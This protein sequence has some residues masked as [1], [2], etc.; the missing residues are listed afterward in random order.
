MTMPE[1]TA[2]TS[3]YKA[4]EQSQQQYR[5]QKSALLY[6]K[7]I[8]PAQQLCMDIPVNTEQI[9]PCVRYADGTVGF[10]SRI[11]Q[12]RRRICWVPRQEA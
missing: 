2:E 4:D 9:Y 11:V 8:R 6:D 5:Q 12:V 1:F 7:A 3:L 10:C